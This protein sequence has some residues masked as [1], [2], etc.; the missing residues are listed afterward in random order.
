MN[1]YSRWAY[2]INRICL[3]NLIPCF[4]VCVYVCLSLGKLVTKKKQY[5]QS[6]CYVNIYILKMRVEFHCLII[7]IFITLAEKF[8]LSLQYKSSPKND[9]AL[10]QRICHTLSKVVE[11]WAFSFGNLI[12]MNCFSKFPSLQSA[13]GWWL[14]SFL[15]GNGGVIL[16]KRG[17]PVSQ[18]MAYGKLVSLNG[19]PIYFLGWKYS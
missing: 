17:I 1:I 16:K 3:I 4:S 10:P 12:L 8:K 14:I 11:A 13:K 7:F 9:N 6:P 15:L 2:R 19:S 18:I 5:M